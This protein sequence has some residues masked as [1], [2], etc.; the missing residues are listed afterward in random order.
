M[1]NGSKEK[2]VS[3]I[4]FL[5]VIR[6]EAYDRNTLSGRSLDNKMK[7]HLHKCLESYSKFMYNHFIIKHDD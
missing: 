3:N 1:T 5:T 2:N 4:F 6:N 7:L